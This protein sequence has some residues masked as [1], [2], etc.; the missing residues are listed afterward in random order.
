MEK[1]K[2]FF[3]L[4]FNQKKKQM[5]RRLTEEWKEFVNSFFYST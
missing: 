2:Q 5:T 1:E 3:S 4:E